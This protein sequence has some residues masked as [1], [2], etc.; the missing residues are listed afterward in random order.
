VTC[1][2][3]IGFDN[4][5]SLGDKETGAKAALPMWLDFMK[6]AVAN[7]PNEQFT[8]PNAPKREIEVAAEPE[9]EG[10]PAAVSPVQEDQPDTDV[11]D[12][13]ETPAAAAPV[14][15]PVAPARMP[16]DVPADGRVPAPIVRR[17]PNAVIA[18]PSRIGKPLTIAKPAVV[19][20]QGKPKAKPAKMKPKPKPVAV[21]QG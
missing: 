12:T 15:V 6:V 18:K 21:P 14:V 4:R 16:D 1:G 11:P 10:K 3:W 20:K 13:S 8:K 5:Q 19:A 7:R 17:K 2:T 9:I